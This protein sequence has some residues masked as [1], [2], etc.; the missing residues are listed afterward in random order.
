[1][2]GK[3]KLGVLA[4]STISVVVAARAFLLYYYNQFD[5]PS[6]QTRPVASSFD[7]PDSQLAVMTIGSAT[8]FEVTIPN[9][10][11]LSSGNSLVMLVFGNA[12]TGTLSRV[13]FGTFGAEARIGGSAPLPLARATHL[14]ARDF[15][16][17]IRTLRIVEAGAGTLCDWRR[18]R[19]RQNIAASFNCVV[20]VMQVTFGFIPSP[21][22]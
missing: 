20:Y 2:K 4:L 17:C 8:R 13:A 7:V 16:R 5:F 22:S 21:P 15:P 6:M 19:R 12:D 14:E 10:V 18:M 11:P 3:L 1:M 9:Q